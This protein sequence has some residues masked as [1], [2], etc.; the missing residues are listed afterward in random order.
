MHKYL[1]KKAADLK[2]ATFEKR[3]LY[4][5]AYPGIFE[6]R[7]GFCRLGHKFLTVLKGKFKCK[8]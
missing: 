1:F 8:H 3:L 4:T 6:G 7:G 5:G 2:S